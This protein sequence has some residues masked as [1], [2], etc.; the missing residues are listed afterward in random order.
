MVV[1]VQRFDCSTIKDDSCSEVTLSFLS[2]LTTVKKI[3]DFLENGGSATIFL[4]QA[5]MGS[6]RFFC[7]DEVDRRFFCLDEVD[8]FD[9][10]LLAEINNYLG[11]KKLD[12]V[13][14]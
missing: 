12:I 2:K 14:F 13:L 6:R 10:Y 1:V 3:D 11:K 4:T 7:L 9:F 5:L 8:N